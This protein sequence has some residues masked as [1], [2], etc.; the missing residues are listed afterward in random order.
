MNKDFKNFT[1]LAITLSHSDWVTDK[2]SNKKNDQNDETDSI[3]TY[4]K[5]ITDLNEEEEIEQDNEF[6]PLNKE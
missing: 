4:D 1:D 6:V 5:K 2:E 3:P